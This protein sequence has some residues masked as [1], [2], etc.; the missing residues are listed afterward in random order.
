M[1]MITEQVIEE[2]VRLGVPCEDSNF[3]D[4]KLYGNKRFLVE[5]DGEIKHLVIYPYK[6][7]VKLSIGNIR[8][9]DGSFKYCRFEP[10]EFNV[11]QAVD[12]L[13]EH[14][15]RNKSK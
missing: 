9:P 3:E 11:E 15:L 13:V 4:L 1:F 6:A 8:L 2:A 14:K 5:I 12:F 7:K 10:G